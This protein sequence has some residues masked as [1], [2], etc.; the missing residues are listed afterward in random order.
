MCHPNNLNNMLIDSNKFNKFYV[1]V[2]FVVL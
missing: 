1:L 2:Y